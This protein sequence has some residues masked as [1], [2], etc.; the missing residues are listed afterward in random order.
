MRLNGQVAVITGAGSGMGREMAKLFVQEGAKVV[1]ADINPTGVVSLIEEISGTPETIE[2]FQ[3][4]VSKR[5][6]C[7]AMLDFAV[8]KFGKLDILCNNAGIMDNMMPISEL[9]DE[10]WDKVL[11]VN[12][13]SVMYASRYAV[14]IMTKQGGGKIVNTAS[15]A[16]LN[17]GRA[18]V[19][20]ATAKFGVIGLTKNIGFM[21]AKQG[22]RCNAICPGAIDTNI[23]SGN[24]PNA[25]GMERAISGLGSNPATGK[26]D[27]VAK[28]A[29][30]LASDDSQYINAT[31]LTIDGGWTA[32]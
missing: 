22:I 29:L 11:S 2:F 30:F 26:P 24:V 23:I 7:E 8:T 4:N 19:T 6:E 18:G 14:Q 17:A 3:C 9:E 21:Y 31:T 20:Y 16:G 13:N 28:A 1:A 32:Y 12:L 5:A 27:Q 10:L 15:I 25:F